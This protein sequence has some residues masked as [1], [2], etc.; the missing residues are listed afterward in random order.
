MKVVTSA[1]IDRVLDP[2]GLADALA[3]AFRSDI[4]VP[5]RHH[6]EVERRDD[7]ATLL[8]MPAWTGLPS[9]PRSS[10]RRSSASTAAI[11]ARGL[12]SV[13][14]SYLLNDGARRPA[15]RFSTDRG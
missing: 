6:H 10:G 11:A 12:P 2:A 7:D 13:Q 15:G 4:V 5:M 14:G 3:Q 1:D 9:R 8:L